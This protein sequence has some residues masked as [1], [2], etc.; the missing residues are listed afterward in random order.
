MV[1]WTTWWWP[2]CRAETCSCYM[3]RSVAYCIVILSDYFVVFWLY[4]Y[5]NIHICLYIV[6]LI[7]M[8]WC[9]GLCSL[10]KCYKMQGMTSEDFI[11]PILWNYLWRF[12]VDKRI[13]KEN[14]LYRF[15]KNQF[16]QGWKYYSARRLSCD[17]S[18]ASSKAS[19]PHTGIYCFLFKVN[20]SF[21]FLK[22]IQQVL[23]FSSSSSCHLYPSFYISFSKLQILILGTRRMWAITSHFC[24]F[25][26]G[27]PSIKRTAGPRVRLIHSQKRITN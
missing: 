25:K 12:W 16:Q 18:T 1:L 22:A 11:L 21:S 10:R 7:I 4:V 19:S 8:C 27:V 9:W 14:G 24:R 26:T 20:I 2:T 13:L 17:R 23:T 6:L 15:L 5:V 3:S